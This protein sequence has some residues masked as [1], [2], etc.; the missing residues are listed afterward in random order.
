MAPRK[1][2]VG[3]RVIFAVRDCVEEPVLK[4]DIGTVIEEWNS[5]FSYGVRWD[6]PFFGNRWTVEQESHLLYILE[7]R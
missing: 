6:S 5:P 7:R 4:R 3:D 2:S 1:F